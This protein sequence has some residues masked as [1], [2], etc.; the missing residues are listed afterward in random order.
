MSVK[1]LIKLARIPF[2][3]SF[4]NFTPFCNICDT[5]KNIQ[6]I[7]L[8]G[9]NNY[10]RCIMD[11][12]TGNTSVGIELSK[13]L[14]S[15]LISVGVPSTSVSEAMVFTI[16]SN[17]GIHEAAYIFTINIIIIYK[18]RKRE[19]VFTKWQF[20]NKTQSPVLVALEMSSAAMGPCPCP[21]E[22][23]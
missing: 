6:Y 15:L 19:K 2:G 20:C 9:I 13:S 18:I 10:L 8:N 21:S 1:V 12:E 4:V 16:F 17:E 3:G 14:N 23:M 5:I 11:T 7:Q 22:I